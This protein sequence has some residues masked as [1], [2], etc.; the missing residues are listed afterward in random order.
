VN[1]DSIRYSYLKQ[2]NPARSTV[3]AA[4]NMLPKELGLD[5]FIDYK[6]QYEKSFLDPIRGI[7]SVIGWNT[8]KVNTL[9][10]FEVDD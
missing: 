7:T 3:I 9:S 4:P 8:S 10:K 6:T 5:A 2:P 1:K